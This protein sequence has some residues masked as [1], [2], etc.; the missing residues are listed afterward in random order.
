M[1]EKYD[2]LENKIIQ[3]ILGGELSFNIILNEGVYFT[4][5]DVG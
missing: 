3:R 1:S 5:D 4:S 2:F